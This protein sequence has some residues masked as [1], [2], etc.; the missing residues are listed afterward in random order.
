M[1]RWMLWA[2]EQEMVMNETETTLADL[3]VRDT[4]GRPYRL[5][6]AW[7]EKPVVLLFAR[8]FG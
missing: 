1:P 8:H 6:D 3:T 5:G 2:P 4:R 7:S